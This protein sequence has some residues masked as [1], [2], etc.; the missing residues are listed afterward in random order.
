MNQ[1][2]E[3]LT[4]FWQERNA[5]ERN[6]LSLVAAVIVLALIYALF[7]D[8]ALSGRAQLAKNL[9]PL[10]LQAAEMQ[11]LA[12][13]AAD[14]ANR[15]APQTSAMSKESLEAALARKALKPQNVVVSGDIAKVQLAAVSFAAMMEWLDEM[16]K[17]SGMSI[18]DASIVALPAIDSVNAT[19][20]LRQQ[21]NEE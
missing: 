3:S 4:A 15:A 21:K 20:T 17:T 6:M 14:L 8:P 1:L 10:R 7:I 11:S 12:R 2:K 18:V 16:Q 9:P 5:R 19:L 13:Q